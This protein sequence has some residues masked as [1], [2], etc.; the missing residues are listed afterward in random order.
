[1]PLAS[2]VGGMKQ[3][4]SKKRKQDELKGTPERVKQIFTLP[5]NDSPVIYLLPAT[6]TDR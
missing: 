6:D 5:T 2:T 4:F 3:W 1:M